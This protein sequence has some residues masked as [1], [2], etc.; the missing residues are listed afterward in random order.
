M[1]KTMNTSKTPYKY[2]PPAPRALP[3]VMPKFYHGPKGTRLPEQAH[4]A[5]LMDMFTYKRP[6][7]QGKGKGYKAFTDT[8]II[9]LAKSYAYWVDEI[10]NVW[11]DLRAD[12]RHR[13]LFTAHTDSV[14]RDEGRQHVA[15][16]EKTGNITVLDGS[17]LGA[18][19]A[20][21]VA[22]LLH[23][24]ENR[25]PAL[26]LF[27]VG[28]EC[29]G[30][31]ARFAADKYAN[32]LMDFD[33]AIA[34][35][36]RADYS[37]ITHQGWGKCASDEFA[38]ALA[39][40]LC[41]DHIMYALDDGGV[42]TDTAEFVDIIAEC[43]NLSIGYDHEHTEREVQNLYHFQH[44]AQAVLT[45]PWDDLPVVREPGDSGAPT[46]DKWGAGA[47][48]SV[49]SGDS[50]WLPD[51]DWFEQEL[52]EA[53]AAALEG[54]PDELVYLAA[55]E[56]AHDTGSSVLTIYHCMIGRHIDLSMVNEV[57]RDLSMFAMSEALL[58]LADKLMS[59]H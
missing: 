39:E 2:V 19:D 8:F 20:S 36:R 44:L 31:G 22:M 57:D 3:K 56:Y 23:L 51:E 11:V 45:V 48:S 30:H 52:E 26:Y 50:G 15:F 55:Q 54:D 16:D 59:T 37:V 1:S 21:G 5:R 29:G 46:W 24:I 41:N 34:F 28:E 7:N 25:V 47:V 27:T 43:T 18:D 12:E 40:Y 13:T 10:G 53:L 14:H 49:V 33:R 4:L 9:P 58:R 42:Y 38:N 17:C 6:Y 35:D 32:L